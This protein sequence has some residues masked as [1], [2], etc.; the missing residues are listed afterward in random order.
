MGRLLNAVFPPHV[1]EAL[2]EGRQV[3]P[4]RREMVTIFSDL[5][6]FTAVRV[7]LARVRGLDDG[8][9]RCCVLFVCSSVCLFWWFD[10]FGADGA[11]ESGID[12]GPRVF[13]PRCAV[14][15]APYVQGARLPALA[16]ILR[17]LLC[18]VVSDVA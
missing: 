17:M 5:V 9:A 14:E 4:E 3:E 11:E 1:A 10:D 6:G 12:A 2:A 16:W 8:A 13:G 7:V 18:V 15:T